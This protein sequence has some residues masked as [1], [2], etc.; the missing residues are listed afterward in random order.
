MGIILKISYGKRIGG[1]GLDSSGLEEGPV[2]G[3]CKQRNEP[4]GPIKGWFNIL[5]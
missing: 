5:K 1:C 2:E 3:F 4:L